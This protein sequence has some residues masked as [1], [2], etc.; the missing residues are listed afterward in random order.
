MK[1]D[2]RIFEEA[3]RYVEA[4]DDFCCAAITNACRRRSINTYWEHDNFF[5]QLFKPPIRKMAD[6]WCGIW[7]STKAEKGT[8]PR[9]IALL[10]AAQ[11]AKEGL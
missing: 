1:L 3:A 2:P 8:E 11:I 9:L 6:T 4:N 5:A 10:L 7:W